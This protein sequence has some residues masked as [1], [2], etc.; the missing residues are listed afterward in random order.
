MNVASEANERIQPS[1][2]METSPSSADP[3]ENVTVAVV[4]SIEALFMPDM[5]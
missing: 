2:K 1:S 5:L 4:L 3:A